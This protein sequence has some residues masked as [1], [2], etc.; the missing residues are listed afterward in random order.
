MAETVNI[1]EIANKLS[2]DI[3]KHFL[4]T[5]HQKHDDNFDCKNPEHVSDGKKSLPKTSHPSDVVF[6]YEDPYLG[7]TIYLHTDL[8]SY[9]KATIS[10]TKIRNAFKSL[11]MTVECAQESPDWRDKYS[12]LDSEPHEVR[13]LLFILNHDHGYAKDF[14]LAVETANLK[15]LQIPPRVMT[16]YLGPHDIQRLYSIGNDIMRLKVEEE[17]PSRYTFYYPDL[18]M[19]RRHGDGSEQAAT[20][21]S[22]IGPFLILKHGIAP[23]CQQGFV[24]YY[25]RRGESVEEFEY[26]LDCLSRFQMLEPDQKLRVRV[27]DAAANDD[28]K[29]VFEK[30]KKKYAKAW[31]FDPARENLLNIIDIDRITSV[32]STYNPGDMGW[33]E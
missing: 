18:V 13:G 2:K 27:T 9:A 10:G 14:Y 5:K 12:V 26:F 15:S 32:S 21:E 25:N 7:K 31:G 6:F 33:R 17:L 3:F 8:K 16:H 11:V 19:V 23:N 20:I 29:S 30:A 22:I 24:I 28:L 1:G 4:W